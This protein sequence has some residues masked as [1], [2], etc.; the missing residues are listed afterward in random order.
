MFWPRFCKEA[1]IT[2]KY[3]NAV[4][5]IESE[6]NVANLRVDWIG[7]VY[8]VVDLKEEL[9]NQPE[10]MQHSWVFQQLGPINEIL[11]KYG[12]SELSYP[13]ISKI[14]GSQSYL[15]SMYPE[16]DYFNIISFI[17]NIIFAGI[18]FAMS[19]MTYSLVVLFMQ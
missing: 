6:L 9:L 16:N 1:W 12:L 4:K 5:S 18:V 14:Q 13:E 17:R 7:R 19:Y 2:R 11:I 10:L 15:V 8:G 3:F